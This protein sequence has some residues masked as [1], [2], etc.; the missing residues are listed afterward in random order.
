MP[1]QGAKLEIEI[2]CSSADWHKLE[3]DHWSITP[4]YFKRNTLQ[5]MNASASLHYILLNNLNKNKSVDL[6]TQNLF[7]NVS[8]PLE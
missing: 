5:N 1:G 2:I 3:P 4:H 7:F 8:F 6:I